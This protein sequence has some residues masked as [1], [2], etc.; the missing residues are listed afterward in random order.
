MTRLKKLIKSILHTMLVLLV[1]YILLLPFE[2]INNDLEDEIDDKSE[3]KKPLF[4][5]RT[6]SYVTIFILTI[7]KEL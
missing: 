1:G 5:A 4:W 7:I 6:G 2:N 3:K